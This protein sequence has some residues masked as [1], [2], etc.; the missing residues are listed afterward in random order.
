M[1]IED[2]PGMSPSAASPEIDQFLDTFEQSCKSFAHYCDQYMRQELGIS[3]ITRHL[4]EATADAEFKFGEYSFQMNMQQLQRY[5][6]T[7]AMLDNL[8]FQ[9]F[10]TEIKRNHAIIHDAI[11][12][13]E[14]FIIGLTFNSIK[15]SI[16]MMYSKQKIKT[17]QERRLG[18]FEQEFEATQVRIKVLKALESVINVD[19][20]AK[21][22]YFKIQK[23]LEIYVNYFGKAEPLATGPACDQ[24]VFN[25]FEQH[26]EYLRHMGFGGDQAMASVHISLCCDTL[27]QIALQDRQRTMIAAWRSLVAL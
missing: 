7:Q 19:D 20:F 27:Q 8:T 15:S 26:V 12:N 9:L 10:D 24:R 6:T 17:E 18:A 2:L 11:K 14:Y 22:D 4:S 25:L 13:G 1:M 16:F 23:A 5:G 21:L 3:D